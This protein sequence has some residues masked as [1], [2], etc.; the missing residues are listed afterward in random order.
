MFQRSSREGEMEPQNQVLKWL[1][2]AACIAE[3]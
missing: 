3:L 2:L 1:N